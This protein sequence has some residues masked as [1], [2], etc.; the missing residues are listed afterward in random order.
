[1]CDELSLAA[2]PPQICSGFIDDILIYSPTLDAHVTHLSIVLSLLRQHQLAVK[3]SKCSFAQSSLEYL[4]HIISD[5]G[6]AIDP[7]KTQAMVQ[8]PRPTTVMEL[9]GF[10]VLTGYYRK[11]VQAYGIIAKPLTTLLKKK[12]FVWTEQATVAFEALK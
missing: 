4:G 7:C 5:H 8:W 3:R 10:L 12:G 1:M 11:F 2:V 9:R 6:V